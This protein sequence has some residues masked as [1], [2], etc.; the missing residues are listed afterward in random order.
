MARER[1]RELKSS[2]CRALSDRAQRAAALV[3]LR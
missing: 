3:N 2:S 1:Y